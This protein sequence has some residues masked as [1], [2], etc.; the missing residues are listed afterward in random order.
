M[1][2][3]RANNNTLSSI[4]ALP[5][6]ISTGG[7][8]H[9]SGTT[10]TAT[11]TLDFTTSGVLDFSKYK[12]YMIRVAGVKDNG[13]AA[14][15]YFRMRVFNSGSIVD[16]GT[17]YKWVYHRHRLSSSSTSASGSTGDSLMDLGPVN[18][19]G[20]ATGM[21]HTYEIFVDFTPYYFTAV[22]TGV[23]YH[24]T[25]TSALT[26]INSA[27]AYYGH[28]TQNVDG[29]RMFMNTGSIEGRI[30]IYGLLNS[31]GNSADL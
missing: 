27:G 20:S 21:E 10:H 8:V 6:A 29:I 26:I 24:N 28:S 5:S 19:S 16:T 1:S 25:N 15:A 12:R 3:L 18:Y 2:I 9:L 7:L 17:N 11:A 30:D 31:I 13:S 14:S 22:C 23:A 4:T